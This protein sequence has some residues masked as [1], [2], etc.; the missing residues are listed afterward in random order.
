MNILKTVSAVALTFMV[1]SASA[2]LLYWQVDGA[3]G[4]ALSGDKY[5][6]TIDFAY[7]TVKAD[8]SLL[9]SYTSEGETAYWKL[10]ATGYRSSGNLNDTTGEPA[11]F[12]S[13]N[14]DSVLS[15]LVELWDGSDNRVG[16]QSYSASALADN[17]WKSDKPA[18]SGG[19]P[20][21]VTGVVP[22][23]TSGL[24]LLL[25]MAGLALRRKRRA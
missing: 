11:Y 22:E 7:A 16:W 13:F 2:D 9:N 20:L 14:S 6:Q 25:G 5:N 21:T 12:G 15:F 1:A 19:T 23:P 3:V 4:N 18:A 8:G 24:L 10:Y 17:I